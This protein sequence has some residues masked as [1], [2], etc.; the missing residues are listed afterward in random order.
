M[1]TITCSIDALRAH[2]DTRADALQ[3]ACDSGFEHVRSDIAELQ[4]QVT[5]IEVLQQRQLESN[6]RLEENVAA[7]V[8]A[9]SGLRAAEARDFVRPVEMQAVIGSHAGR[10]DLLMQMRSGALLRA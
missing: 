1:T 8:V 9:A 3:Q 2:C 5:R 6:A 4:G 10:H 7:L